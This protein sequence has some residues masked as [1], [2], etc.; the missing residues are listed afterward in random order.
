MDDRVT[1]FRV[2]V[3]VVATCLIAGLL[4]MLFGEMPGL[5]RQQYTIFVRFPEAPGVTVDTPVT[6][7]G[8]LVGR[9]TQVTLL[10]EQDGAVVVT[11]KVDSQRTLRSNEVCRI[12]SG[13]ILG[14]A[15]LEFVPRSRIRQP[16]ATVY[17]DGDYLDGVVGKDPLAVMETATSALQMLVNLEN[18]V[19]QALDSIQQAGRQVGSVAE[20]MNAVVANNADQFQR[21]LSKSEQ[22]MDRFDFAMTAI[23]RFVRDDNLKQKIEEA[24][25]QVPELMTDASDVMA[26][27]KESIGTFQTTMSSVQGS[28][29]SFKDIGTR[30]DS[31]GDSVESV[32]ARANK[33]LENLEGLT[34]PLGERGPVLAEKL[35]SS[36]GKFDTLLAN[37]IS[38]S[39]ALNNREGTLGQLLYNREMY[40][41]VNEAVEEINRLARRVGP[42][43]DRLEPI[44]NDVRIFTDK[45]ARDPRQLGVKGALDRRQSQTKW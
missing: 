30:I 15:V 23:D 6:K 38:F 26:A 45:V 4:I 2:G 40:D 12:S 35:E 32:M 19:R 3:L 9:V 29:D 8:I 42:V 44:V 21:I 41:R 28:L 1:Q 43:V 11:L 34:E 37:L 20:G 27:L 36:L 39:D 13:S 22:A 25:S 33:N 24:I 14:D 31:L 17:R 5:L 16:N 10:D 7:S 18:D